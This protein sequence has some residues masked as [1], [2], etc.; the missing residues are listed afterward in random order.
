VRLSLYVLTVSGGTLVQSTLAPLVGVGG[1]VPD[2]LVVLVV[3]LGLRLGPEAGCLTGFAFGLVQDGVAGGPFGLHALSKAVIGFAAGDLPRWLGVRRPA[4]TIAAA[5]LASV[6]DGAL[7]FGLLQ[8]FQYPAPFGELLTRV[9][10]PQAGYNTMLA[11]VAVLV[12]P[13]RWRT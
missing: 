12:P 13:S 1:V 7:R 9:I 3:L 11:A 6:A 5:A 2:V 4:V 10:L 8:L